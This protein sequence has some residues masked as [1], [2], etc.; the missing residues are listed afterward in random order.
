MNINT[1][2]NQ[3]IKYIALLGVIFIVI[4]TVMYI[5]QEKFIFF[6]TKLPL[7]Y[8]F[9]FNV[10]FE[11]QYIATNDDH[12][13]HGILFKAD[14]S[15]GVILYL[16]GNAGAV[17]SWG[18]VAS[19]Y[20]NL[21]YDIFILDYRGYGKSEGEIQNE[22][23]FYDDIQLVYDHLKSI[24][25]EDEIIILGCSIG[26]GAAAKVASENHPKM[27]ILLAPYYSLVDVMHQFYP[28]LPGFILKYQFKTHKFLKKTKA[29]IVLFHGNKDEVIDYQSSLKLQ[30]VLKPTDSL[31]TLKNQMHNGI[32]HNPEYNVAL[33][34]IL[35]PNIDL[36]DQ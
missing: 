34:N 26:T 12:N 21:N 15:K 16:H 10:P 25:S 24:Y 20:T 19:V 22:Q 32:D 27:L 31:I 14:A 6:P 17:N 30:K 13:L 11:E 4:C 5:A 28:F 18:E 35:K 8:T 1:L 2:I 29:P 36:K 7:D 23:Q 3:A 9:N 33:S